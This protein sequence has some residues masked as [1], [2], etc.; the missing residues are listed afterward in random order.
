VLRELPRF[1]AVYFVTLI[2]N[3][4]LLPVALSV[5]TFNIYVVQ[6]LLTVFVVVSSYLA[7][8][9]YSFGGGRHRDAGATAINDPAGVLEE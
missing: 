4:A 5:L 8:R 6:A 1:S 2:A 3:L 7:H 9:Y